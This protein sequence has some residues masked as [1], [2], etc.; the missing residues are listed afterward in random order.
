MVIR[1]CLKLLKK[2][3]IIVYFQPAGWSICKYSMFI[4]LSNL[5]AIKTIDAPLKWSLLD[6]HWFIGSMARRL[7]SPLHPWDPQ[8]KWW[9]QVFSNGGWVV[10]LNVGCLRF[11]LD[12]TCIVLWIPNYSYKENNGHAE[13]KKIIILTRKRERK[14]VYRTNITADKKK[15]ELSKQKKKPIIGIN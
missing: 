1:C 13:A 3:W 4:Y 9:G 6:H 5:T 8:M 12:N 10:F 7:W 14:H 11:F 15:V 2:Q